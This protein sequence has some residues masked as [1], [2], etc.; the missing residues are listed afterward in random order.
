MPQLAP[1]VLARALVF[2]IGFILTG[3]FWG[4][5]VLGVCD[6]CPH[7][8]LQGLRSEPSRYSAESF[9]TQ[10]GSVSAW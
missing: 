7:N 1:R 6:Y 2:L 9:G 10:W 3:F 4:V 8:A 5:L